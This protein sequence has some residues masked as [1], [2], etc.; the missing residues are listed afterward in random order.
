MV[1]GD[2]CYALGILRAWAD[3]GDEYAAEKLA[4]LL[5]E[6][7]D[8]DEL[9]VR[10]D[11]GDGDAAWELAGLLA[12]RGDLDGLRA[13][14]VSGDLLAAGQLAGRGD[15][16]GLRARADP[17]TGLPPG[18]WPFC[19]PSRAA[20]KKQSGCA[21]SALTRTDQ[22]LMRED[23]ATYALKVPAQ[24][25]AGTPE[26]PAAYWPRNRP[27]GPMLWSATPG[28]APER[29]PRR[30]PEDVI[31][32]RYHVYRLTDQVHSAWSAAR[33]IRQ[34]ELDG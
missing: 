7:G 15:L 31:T 10:A 18:S 29:Y 21:G 23:D 20:V 5:A 2:V 25:P 9:R 12:R 13:R 8:I 1:F 34:V 19:W 14:A 11:A 27:C 3:A 22:L 16:D 24:H 17:A 32:A 30:W 28:S 6:R 33:G 4:G 26:A